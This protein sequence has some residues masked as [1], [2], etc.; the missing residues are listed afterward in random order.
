MLSVEDGAN[1][2]NHVTY[3]NS[4][5]VLRYPNPNVLNAKQSA[6]VWCLSHINEKNFH[7]Q[8]IK[9]LIK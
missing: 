3:S 1:D 2:T 5:L 8:K 6:R 7:R 4:F 9:Y